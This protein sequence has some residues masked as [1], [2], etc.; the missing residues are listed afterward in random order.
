LTV[1]ANLR[2]VGAKARGVVLVFD[3]GEGS[4]RAI[5]D[6]ADLTAIRTA[7]TAAVAAKTLGGRDG[8][9]VAV[10]GSGPV[11]QRL[12]EALPCVLTPGQWRL[13][14]RDRDRA[15]ALAT[16]LRSGVDRTVHQ[17]PAEATAD[18]DIVVTCTPAR[19]PLLTAGGLGRA[20]LILAMGADS[21]GKQEL[22]ADVLVGAT[23]VADDPVAARTV[24]ESARLTEAAPDP[25][26]LGAAILAGGN[27]TAGRT[28][29][30]SVGTA[31]TDTAVAEV[32]VRLAAEHGS[33]VPF[34]FR[35]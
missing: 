23:V 33:G 12:V 8:D 27:G 9:T 22:A 30:D 26:H 20:R 32:I 35:T 5:I 14:S 34:S 31:F 11:A 16:A 21:P 28:V 6:S 7:A 4:L 2:P 29:V 18:A 19:E 1:K 3:H 24:G 13:W 10:I 17:T 25:V 15:D